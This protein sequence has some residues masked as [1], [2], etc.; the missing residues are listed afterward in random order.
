MSARPAVASDELIVVPIVVA[1][2]PIS[3][4]AFELTVGIDPNVPDAE[5]LLDQVTE[6]GY[7]GIDLGPVGY[8]GRGEILQE[9][10]GERGLGLAGGYLELPY[11]DRTQLASA[12][13]SLDELL[14]VFD[15]VP[16]S[17][18]RHGRRSP[19]PAP[20]AVARIRA[21]P[22]R[23]ASTAGRRVSGVASQKGWRASP[24]AAASAAMSRPSTTRPG[25]TSRPRGRSSGCSS[26]PTSGSA[27][28]PAIS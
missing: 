3:Y 12:M 22:R 13:S 1:N 7:D 19:T 27:W 18:P 9:R 17:Y 14:S 23:T 20:P 25:P 4:G 2:A 16:D 6:A 11:T 28:T 10:L 24:T 21:V 5:M 8:L 15:A 26:Y